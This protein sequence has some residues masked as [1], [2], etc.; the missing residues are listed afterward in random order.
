[1]SN[2]VFEPIMS[3]K[4]SPVEA[5]RCRSEQRRGAA[6]DVYRAA[7]GTNMPTAKPAKNARCREPIL[8]IKAD[9]SLFNQ[10]VIKSDAMRAP[11]IRNK[12][13]RI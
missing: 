6:N 3:R 7:N 5:T 8:L 4:A 9:L 2:S 10:I 11:L 12:Q 1:M 13:N